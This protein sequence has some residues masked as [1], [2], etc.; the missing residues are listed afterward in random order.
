VINIAVL[1]AHNCALNHAGQDE[2]GQCSSSRGLSKS[3]AFCV[4]ALLLLGSMSL[5]VIGLWWAPMV[6]DVFA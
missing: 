2:L 5:S 1:L 4:T 6:A 3:D